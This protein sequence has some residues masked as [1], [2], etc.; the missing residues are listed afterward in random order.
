MTRTIIP[1][2]MV[3]LIYQYII[4]SYMQYALI[5]TYNDKKYGQIIHKDDEKY[6]MLRNMEKGINDVDYFYCIFLCLL[7]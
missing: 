3:I 2:I 4:L 6:R 7:R 5:N 1:F